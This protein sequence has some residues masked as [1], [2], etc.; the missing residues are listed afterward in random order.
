MS[1]KK[2]LI[3]ELIWFISSIIGGII[4]CLFLYSLIDVNINLIVIVVGVIVVLLAVYVVRLTLWVFKE[5]I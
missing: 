5:S 2:K 1:K 3:K 4:L